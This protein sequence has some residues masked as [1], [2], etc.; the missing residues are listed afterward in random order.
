MGRWCEKRGYDFA[1]I[2]GSWLIQRSFE[3]AGLI[4]R[5]PFKDTTRMGKA[6]DPRGP[7]T[8]GSRD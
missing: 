3:L 7:L 2:P 4:D 5:L 6:L 1:L 8:G